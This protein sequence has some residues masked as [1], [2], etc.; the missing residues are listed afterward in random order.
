MRRTLIKGAIVVSV[1]PKIGNLPKGDI[2]IDGKTIAAVDRDLGNVDATIIDG[3]DMIVIPGFV[4]THRHTWQ[5]LLRGTAAD[6]TLGQY[7]GG[8]RGI[9]G[10]LYTPEDMYVANYVGALDALDAGI[11]TLY[12]WSHLNN[13]PAHADA[14]V[15][16]LHDAGIRSIY[17][18]G[19]S[20]SQ[21]A[22]PSDEETD[23]ADLE[24]IRKKFFS[25]DDGLHGVAFAARGPQ[26]TP[27]D[28]SVKEFKKAHDMG[29]RITVHCGD[30]L[31]GLDNPITKLRDN[32]CLFPGTIYVHSCT[33]NDDEF[34]MVA[35]SGGFVSM[36]P[37]V[38]MNMGHGTVASWGSLKAGMRP[39][40]SIDVVTS[41]GSDMFT[42]MRIIMADARARA[43]AVALKER[44]L[45]D[46][47]PIMIT[48][49]LEF[50]TLA[51]AKACGLDHKVGSITPGKEADLV[52]I[53]TN[54]LNLF[55]MNNPIGSVVE[56]ANVGNID[57]VFVQG[58][59]VK[60]H[61]KLVDVDLR[62]L[63]KMMDT[64]RDSLFKRANVPTDGTWLP[65]PHREGTDVNADAAE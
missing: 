46:P 57:T 51:G 58:R 44:K 16:G 49:V 9:M 33:A 2:L 45:L 54:A 36:S 30:G 64:Q 63:R 34:K 3:T 41:I 6:W 4:D 48:D 62:A 21:W 35:D 56:N 37:E 5:S 23:F 10:K 15:K 43:N 18:Y 47:L 17:G 27:L 60:R 26:F 42:A 19:N 38:E 22:V 50:A 59:I 12:D 28:L 40:I 65:V 32:K 8:V 11:T 13:T 61:G 39:T 7:F 29:L 20:N 24:R 53:D 1:D 31:W 25:S 55:P 52:M 14:A